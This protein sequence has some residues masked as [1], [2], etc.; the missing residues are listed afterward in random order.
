MALVSGVLKLSSD[1][2]GV[3]FLCICA[4]L[5]NVRASEHFRS[6]RINTSTGYVGVSLGSNCDRTAFCCHSRCE[7]EHPECCACEHV[8]SQFVLSGIENIFD[9]ATALEKSVQHEFLGI[10]LCKSFSVAV[11]KYGYQKCRV[12]NLK[13]G[14]YSIRWVYAKRQY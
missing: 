11:L 13:F 5:I 4:N 1:S 10:F 9:I 3:C 2:N 8:V 7:N 6:D 12:I 14:E